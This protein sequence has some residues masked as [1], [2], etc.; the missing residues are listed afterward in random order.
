MEI[1]RKVKK[2]FKTVLPK[3]LGK[4]YGFSKYYT[5][6]QVRK[7]VADLW[8]EWSEM[9]CYAYPLFC[10][11]TIYEQIAERCVF[12]NGYDETRKEF[13][14]PADNTQPFWRGKAEISWYTLD[15][16]GPNTLSGG[17]SG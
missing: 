6:Q 14:V 1:S 17:G 7:T 9:I 8:P 11:K 13:E 10:E 5:W 12:E 16:P 3:A 4:R 15:S 2:K